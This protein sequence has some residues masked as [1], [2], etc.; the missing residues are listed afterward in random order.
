MRLSRLFNTTL[1][2]PPAQVEAAGHQL[3]IQAGYIRPLAS[4]IFCYLPLA[5]KALR[6]ISTII[7]EEMASIGGQ[8]VQLPLVH[9]AEIWQETGRWFSIMDEMG[10]FKDRNQHDMVLAMT[11]EEAVGAVTR[12]II[13]SYRQ[14]PTLIYQIQLKWRDDP[15]PRAG[16]IRTREFSM[17]DSYSLDRDISGLDRQYEAHYEAYQR[18]FQRCDLPVIAVRSD[19]GMMGGQEAHEFMYLNPIGEDTIISCSTCGYAANRQIAT[20]Q[21][22]CEQQEEPKPLS[23]IETPGMKTIAELSNFL[24]IPPQKTAKAIFLMALIADQWKLILAVVRGDLELNE[25]KLQRV[26]NAV[27][28][29]P[30]TDDEIRSSGAVPGF[31]SPIGLDKILVVVDDEIPH[32]TNLVAGANE[33]DLHLLNTNYGRDYEA[34]LIA[35]I[36]YAEEGFACPKCGKPLSSQRGVEVGNIFKLG[37]F[38]SE[39]M[40]CTFL[41]EDGSQRPIVMGSYGIGLGRLLACVAEEHHDEFGLKLPMNVAPYPIHLIQLDDK[42]G[43]VSKRASVLYHSIR[44]NNMEVLYD[45]RDLRA[46]VKFNDADLLGMPIRITISE[47]SLAQ[48]GVEVKLRD[49]KEKQIIKFDEI[50]SYLRLQSVQH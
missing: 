6:R 12:E 30:A 2:K 44:S 24:H 20:F 43:I 22:S 26:L 1:R 46:G 9:P 13:Q 38:Y 32:R 48:D 31:A 41:D 14:L 36:T 5:Q 39:K 7:H 37:T 42:E 50:I 23:S 21:K 19:T 10:R 27:Q 17:L 8:E 25:S 18:I 28:L 4:G 29:R 33:T 45:D 34:D 35:D 47:R 40:G 15:R 11:H 49:E 16:L 3:L